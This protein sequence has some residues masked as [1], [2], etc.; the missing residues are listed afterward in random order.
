MQICTKCQNQV[1]KVYNCQHTMEKDFCVECY[2]EIH[3]EIT[4][5][6]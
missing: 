6:D 1:S 5:C 2:T 4:K 3:Y